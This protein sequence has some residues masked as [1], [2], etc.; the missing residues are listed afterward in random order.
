MTA[1]SL[2]YFRTACRTDKT[3]QCSTKDNDRERDTQEENADKRSGGK[4]KQ[5]LVLQSTFA[6]THH[7]FEHDGEHSRL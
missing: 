6:N 5:G 4:H 3:D 1:L 2:K 7:G